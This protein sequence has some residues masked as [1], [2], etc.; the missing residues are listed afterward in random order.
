MHIH[1]TQPMQF[2]RSSPAGPKKSAVL[3]DMPKRE[4][5]MEHATTMVAAVAF[6]FHYLNRF[7]GVQK[8]PVVRA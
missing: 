7:V 4:C 1:Q 5:Q 6:L 3:D 2:L 8:Q